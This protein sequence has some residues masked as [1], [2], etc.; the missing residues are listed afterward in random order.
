MSKKGTIGKALAVV[1]AVAVVGGACYI[2]R[3]K[4]KDSKVYKNLDVDGKLNKVKS[5]INDNLPVGKK[6]A[7]DDEEDFFFDED[8]DISADDFFNEEDS[9]GRGYTS[10]NP[11]SLDEVESEDTTKNDEDFNV[12]DTTEDEDF[13]EVDDDDVAADATSSDDTTN[14]S[15]VSND[16]PVIPTIDFTNTSVAADMTEIKADEDDS[17]VEG[18]EYEGLSDVSEDSD[19]LAEEDLIDGP[20]D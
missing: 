2:F 8:E 10:I 18:Y 20:L 13:T 7:A 6:E 11:S 14:T 15:P 5:L 17:T 9:T 16:S 19:V 3:D 4:I 12:D 1:G